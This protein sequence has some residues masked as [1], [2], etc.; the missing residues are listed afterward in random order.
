ML[1]RWSDQRVIGQHCCPVLRRFGIS[2]TQQSATGVAVARS[3]SDIRS[4]VGDLRSRDA[5]VTIVPTMGA[6]HA[7]HIALIESSVSRGERVVVSIFVNP[8]Q[9]AAHEDLSSY[10]RQEARD[11][12]MAAE[13]GATAIF[14]PSPDEVYPDGFA[15]SIQVHGP[16][17]GFEGASRPTHFAGVA[18][19]VAKL[20]L[21][22]RPDTIVLGQKDAQQVAVVRRVMTDLNLDDISL[23]VH[24]IV[25]EDDGV[26][27]SSRNRY[28]S[29]QERL[30]ARALSRTL[31][32]AKDLVAR[33]E[34]DATRIADSA[35][36]ML[37]ASDGVVPD[38]AAL[39]DAST[40]APVTHIDR[41]TLL[42][43][44]AQVGPARLIDNSFLLID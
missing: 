4:L 9:F 20:L 25:R 14:A 24:P 2:S 8:T 22:T 43:V 17:Q 41:N 34:R 31:G 39:V 1:S 42:C 28:L 21:M 36:A 7:G 11:I 37:N 18:T 19:V 12:E 16:A 15:T 40:F 6:L 27:M 10:P 26:A 32:H 5:H 44:A 30:N 29:S 35:L 33:G 3:I 13:A 23:V 38:Y